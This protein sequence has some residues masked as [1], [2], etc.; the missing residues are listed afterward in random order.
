[1]DESSKEMRTYSSTEEIAHALTHGMAVLASIVGLAV[2][3][4]LASIHGTAVHISAVS[5]YGG[6][7]ILLYTASTVY[8]SIPIA[9]VRPLL[10]M[11]D[12]AAI[13]VLIAGSYTP[14]A[15]IA[16]ENHNGWWLFAIVWGLAIVGVIFKLF[17]TGRFDKLSVG[18]YLAMGWLVVFYAQPLLDTVPSGGLVLLL[19]GGLAYSA[20]TVF[21]LWRSLR[22]NHT[23][24]HLFVILGSV[25]QFLA[26]VLF[27]IPRSAG[28][29]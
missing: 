29:P 14:F 10:L 12:H 18:L 3:V 5:I 9:S 23:M 25:L 2:M 11:L 7:L 19:A 26:V 24:W 16:L 28:S 13:Y 15:L 20:G 8:H 6:S 17:Y 4:G 27:V 21:Y 1:M 22:F